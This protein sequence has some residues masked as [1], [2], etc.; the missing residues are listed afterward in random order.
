M[1]LKQQTG[2]YKRN[3][4]EITMGGGERLAHRKHFILMEPQNHGLSEKMY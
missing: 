2:Y 3:T 1:R 4:K